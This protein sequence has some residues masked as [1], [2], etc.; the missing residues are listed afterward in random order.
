M[1]EFCVIFS[2]FFLAIETEQQQNFVEQ[3][4]TTVNR[5]LTYMQVSNEQALSHRLY[6]A[7]VIEVSPDVSLLIV[8]PPPEQACSAPG[9]GEVLL[10]RPDLIPLPVQASKNSKKLSIK[11]LKL[12][13]FR[14]ERRQR[15]T[16]ATGSAADAIERGVETGEMAARRV[17][18]RE[19]QSQ[20]DTDEYHTPFARHEPETVSR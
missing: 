7:E 6:D 13:K 16:I 14:S 8:V 20:P 9:Q 2:H 12:K 15:A 10:Q 5:L 4:A 3:V 11:T 19:G 17:G 1:E 18:L